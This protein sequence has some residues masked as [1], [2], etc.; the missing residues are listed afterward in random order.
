MFLRRKDP[1]TFQY[2]DQALARLLPSSTA[3]FLIQTTKDK[4]SPLGFHKARVI[5]RISWRCCFGDNFST[6]VLYWGFSKIQWRHKPRRTS[7][8]ASEKVMVALPA[9]GT[10]SS[11]R[12]ASGSAAYHSATTAYKPNKHGSARRTV[13]RDQPRVV[14]RPKYARTS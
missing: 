13:W 3:F 11:R 9:H 14:S 12:S 2:R 5:V 1:P 6:T 7:V 4:G 8:M 10:T